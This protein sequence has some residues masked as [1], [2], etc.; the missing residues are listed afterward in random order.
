MSE[1]K[2]FFATLPGI[3]TGL[4]GLITAVVALIYALSETGI[5]DKDKTSNRAPTVAASTQTTSPSA[6]QPNPK[7]IVPAKKDTT[8]GWAIIGKY[9]QGKFVDLELMVESDSPA[10]G[11]TYKVVNNFRL[12][13][14]PTFTRGEKTITL[15]VV[16]RG[17]SVEVLDLKVPS[18]AGKTTSPVYAK[19]RAELKKIETMR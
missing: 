10:I 19:L 15:G 11:K 6:Q 3:L 7:T 5:I 9:R 2:S 13:Q 8:D 12:I 1:P 17:D 14:K 18:V 4:A 16:H